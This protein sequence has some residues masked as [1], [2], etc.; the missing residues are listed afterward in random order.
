MFDCVRYSE[1]PDK[2]YKLVA[3][4]P[5]YREMEKDAYDIIAQYTN[6]SELMQI[7]QPNQKEGKVDMC[8]AITE[9]INRGRAEGMQS[10]IEQSLRAIVANML[11]HDVPD[12]TIRAYTECSQELIETVR[13]EC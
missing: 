13:M 3:D 5:S 8:T 6:T 10:G 1:E 11:R 9:L 2:L 7:K 4:D 12:E